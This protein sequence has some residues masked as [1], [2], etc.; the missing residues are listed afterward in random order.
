MRNNIIFSIIIVT[1]FLYLNIYNYINF[2][3]ENDI[4]LKY[5]L[6]YTLHQLDSNNKLRVLT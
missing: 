4:I 5:K 6:Y 1:I 3:I 2:N